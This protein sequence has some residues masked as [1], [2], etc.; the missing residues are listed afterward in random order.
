MNGNGL[1]SGTRFRKT[2]PD[3]NVLIDI[4]ENSY[5]GET[6]MGEHPNGVV[7]RVMMVAAGSTLP[8]DASTG[9]LMLKIICY[10]SI[11][12]G[13]EYAIGDNSEVEL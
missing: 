10:S 5:E 9:M 1:M 4:D 3:V 2:N 13:I 6:S 8:L 11:L 7:S 12:G